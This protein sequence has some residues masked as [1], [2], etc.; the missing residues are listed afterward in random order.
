MSLE[1]KI[2]MFDEV[3]NQTQHVVPPVEICKYSGCCRRWFKTWYFIVPVV[4]YSVLYN[5]PKFF[6]LQI[7]W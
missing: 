7:H 3:Y 6:E 4:V 5:L 2:K 1:S